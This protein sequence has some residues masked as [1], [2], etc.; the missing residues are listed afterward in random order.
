MSDFKTMEEQM[1]NVDVD[2]LYSALFK[3]IKKSHH[4]K[5]EI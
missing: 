2:A 5:V 1:S 4:N 3:K